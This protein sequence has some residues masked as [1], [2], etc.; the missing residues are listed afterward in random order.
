MTE[1]PGPS[2]HLGGKK[3]M[4]RGVAGSLPVPCLPVLPRLPY[5]LPYFLDKQEGIYYQWMN[6]HPEKQPDPF[7]FS[8]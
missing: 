1:L 3:Q 2:P 4:G 5:F 6:V 8:L 7:P